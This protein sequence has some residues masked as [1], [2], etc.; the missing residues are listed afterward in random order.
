MWDTRRIP[1]SL[2]PPPSSAAAPARPRSAATRVSRSERLAAAPLSAENVRNRGVGHNFAGVNIHPPIQP[3]LAVSQPG[4]QHEQEAD[5]VADEVMHMPEARATTAAETNAARPSIAMRPVSTRITPLA[6]R[7]AATEREPQE[8]PEESPQTVHTAPI[9][10]AA[11]LPPNPSLVQRQAQTEDGKQEDEERGPT[12]AVAT[13]PVV[14]G[15]AAHVPSALEAGLNRSQ[16]QGAPL[17]VSARGFFEPRFGHDFSQVRIHADGDAASANRRLNAQAF[18]RGRDIYFGPGRYQPH[19]ASG[20]QLLAHELTH[21][22]QQGVADVSRVGQCNEK[23]GLSLGFPGLSPISISKSTSALSR[24]IQRRVLTAAEESA[25][26]ISGRG[27]FNSITLRVLQT[28]TGVPA[29]DRD[30][31]IGSQTVRAIS[32]WQTARG[33]TDDGI[34]NL[35]S[36]DR[37]VTDSLATGRAEHGI[38]L[39]L[40]YFNLNTATDTLTVRHR[41]GATTFEG[42][43]FVGLFPRP[44]FSPGSTTF[45]EGNLRV[46]EVGDPAFI[47]A[48]TLRNTIQRELARAAPARTPVGATPARLNA[49]Q[50]RAAISYNVA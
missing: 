15:P 13:K 50:V 48:T 6:Q 12:E 3:K 36:L 41:T 44:N 26:I 40:D 7:Q 9:S 1:L 22:V 29:A 16:G 33:L 38:Q 37:L 2:L 25:A 11:A 17:P 5:R 35:A 21:V 20:R 24:I 42:F 46:I 47:D 43:T 28:I 23:R 10:A 30:G 4:D 49:A 8:E 34:V 14:G 27:L 39:V 19:S 45:E 31:V 32:D 18:T